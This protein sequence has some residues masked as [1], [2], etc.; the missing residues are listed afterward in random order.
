[1]DVIKVQMGRRAKFGK[2][3]EKCQN[4]SSFD[5]FWDILN[6]MKDN[7]GQE[8]VKGGLLSFQGKL[9]ETAPDVPGKMTF[10]QFWPYFSTCPSLKSGF[11]TQT[12]IIFLKWAI[13]GLFAGKFHNVI[14]KIVD[15][16]ATWI[17]GYFRLKS[18]DFPDKAPI[19]WGV[20]MVTK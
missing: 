11:P 17:I 6:K 8:C 12:K 10:F 5:I 16:V 19:V 1:M 7:L 9:K 14:F 3:F 2:L 20:A 18:S 13:T 4:Y 15:L